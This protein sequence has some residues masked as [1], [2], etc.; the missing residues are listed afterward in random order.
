VGG[1][2]CRLDSLS[3]TW[4]PYDFTK[5]AAEVR[6]LLMGFGP[7]TASQGQRPPLACLG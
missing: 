1:A 7:P 5:A 4:S 3:Q 2:E 6:T